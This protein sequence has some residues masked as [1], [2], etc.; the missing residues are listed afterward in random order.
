[1]SHRTQT[2]LGIIRPSDVEPEQWANGLG[3]TRVMAAQPAWRISIAE[4]EGR[5]PFSFFPGVDRVLVPL[6]AWGVAL[7]IEDDHHWICAHSAVSFRGEDR[8]IGQTGLR[9][10]T[11]VNVMTR[12]SRAR[13]D[14]EIRRGPG[15]D[16]EDVDA[17]VVLGGQVSAGAG[18]L[19]QGTVILRAAEPRT[20]SSET[21]SVALLRWCHFS[22]SSA[23][24]P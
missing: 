17:F 16:A 23:N 8:V 4:I 11:V 15:M 12:R 6:S 14:C 19:P 2:E 13:L 5:M 22:K 20:V 7:E 10:T 24:Q 21:G 3:A 18:W 1:M 9:R